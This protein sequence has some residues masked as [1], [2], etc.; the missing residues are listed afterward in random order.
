MSRPY[1]LTKSLF[2][3][4]ANEGMIAFTGVMVSGVDGS[5]GCDGV[6]KIAAFSHPDGNGYL[7]LTFILDLDGVPGRRAM[8][9]ARFRRADQDTLTHRLG[10]DFEMLLD[11]QLDT[12]A[13][14]SDFHIEELNLY[15]H[16]LAGRERALL[17][18]WVIPALAHLFEFQIE[19]LDWL[20]ESHIGSGVTASKGIV[21][22]DLTLKQ[23]LKR[24]L[25]TD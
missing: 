10:P 16:R 6:L 2:S 11:M 14:S 9:Q 1:D 5:Q 23:R 22:P 18:D 4:K 19:P 20:R 8:L 3:G 24:W 12:S 13:Q 7:T 15:F 21:R 17:E 25:S